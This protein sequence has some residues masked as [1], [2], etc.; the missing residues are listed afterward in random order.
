MKSKMWFALLTLLIL[1]IGGCSNSKT[2]NEVSN[3]SM[4]MAHE[5]MDNMKIGRAHV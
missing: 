1:L 2:A 3:K 5:G 4:N